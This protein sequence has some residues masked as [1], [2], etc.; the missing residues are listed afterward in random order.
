MSLESVRSGA[1]ARALAEQS[2]SA[3]A[4]A[5]KVR[6][7]AVLVFLPALVTLDFLGTAEWDAYLEP[8]VFFSAF[9]TAAYVLRRRSW[10][11]RI[12]PYSF[13]LDVVLVF[14]MQRRSMPS[15]PFPSGVA[16]FSLGLFAMLLAMAS[17]TMRGRATWA[18]A[19]VSAVAQVTLMRVAGV[20]VGA[21]V[22]AVMVLGIV[23]FSETGVRA[24]VLHLV[25]GL[26]SAEVAWR[27]E[28]EQVTELTEAR[29][30]IE[31]LLVDARAQNAQMVALQA[32]KESLTSLLVHDLRAPLGA[33]R[34]NLDWVKGELPNDF[35]DEVI[36]ALTE[37]RQVTDRLAGMIGDLLNITK[38]ESGALELVRRPQPCAS[39]L[40]NLHK[41]LAAQARG[42]RISVELDVQ[43][44]VL[45][46][47]HAL[48]MRTLENIASNALRYTP[49]GGRIRL[50]A[51]GE[52]NEV[53]FAVRNDGPV[54]PE[55]ARGALF[56]KFVQA[57]SAQEN[58][59]AGW[60]LGL[61]FC[62]LCVDAH[63]GHIG[64]QDEPGWP[65]SFV[66]R[67]PGV[68]TSQR[69]T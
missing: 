42:R 55:A 49:S 51:R 50:E 30:T 22:L 45:E 24:R 8:M 59:R 15:S 16:G 46:A 68:V 44:V 1:E 37:S 34:A 38:L 39:M 9:T 29:A 36:S 20:G 28:H 35:D 48:L 63:R 2:A 53:L 23:A 12:A 4:T 64:V 65:T 5:A 41:Q 61:Y 58:R 6:F 56:D 52:A 40:G 57:G 33:V 47:D 69:A 14:E 21:Q 11:A 66:I 43:D 13:V 19:V 67:I 32:D 10:M 17:S 25:R 18:V 7:I 27:R 3:T 26:A 31:R 62:K 60:G 54:I